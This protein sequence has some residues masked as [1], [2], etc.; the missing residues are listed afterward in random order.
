L[1]YEIA[2]IK[3]MGIEIKTGVKVGKDITLSQ[4]TDSS[5]DAIL[6]ATGSKDT[7]KL[8]T[9]GIN[10][11]GIYDG[12]E[13]LEAVYVSGVHNYLKNEKNNSNTYR[14]GKQVIVIGGGGYSIRL[15]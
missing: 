12:Y 10:L 8:D 5:I 15:C 14:L 2:R 13:F 6:I 11:R 4:L 3:G 9:P 7:V 1:L